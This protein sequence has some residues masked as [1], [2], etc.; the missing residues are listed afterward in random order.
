MSKKNLF[1]IIA[2]ILLLAAPVWARTIGAVA[3]L[4][5]E[6][7]VERAGET[8]PL[9]MES[10]IHL[11]D[12]VITR[13]NA[14]LQILFDDETLLS[15]GEKSE[16]VMDEYVYDPANPQES[17]FSATLGDG[18]FRLITGKLTELN[19]D[20]F[21]LKT[22]RSTIG[23]R[24]TTVGI[25]NYGNVNR[26]MLINI[27]AGH[28]VIVSPSGQEG[29]SRSYNQSGQ[30]VGF[31]ESGDFTE[32][33]L[34]DDEVN[35]LNNQTRPGNG[36]DKNEN[37][38]KNNNGGNDSGETS[39]EE[40]ESD[41]QD[42]SD[43]EQ[44]DAEN[45]SGQTMTQGELAIL[46]AKKIV[47]VDQQPTSMSEITAVNFLLQ[48]GVLPLGGWQPDEPLSLGA[49]AMILGQLLSLNPENPDDE[50]SWLEAGILEG[51]DFTDISSALLT[52][53]LFTNQELATLLGSRLNDP[54][55]REPPGVP[56]EFENA[57]KDNRPFQPDEMTPNR[58]R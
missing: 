46:L 30:D 11:M 53:G 15:L 20:R 57:G 4:E 42:D 21:K 7:V 6:A 17:G 35:N 54:V 45:E 39:G 50:Q 16:V 44:N 48:A 27:P 58:P 38:G 22:S 14:K 19:P 47:P 55:D 34:N 33:P 49:L 36:I 41:D 1:S 18:L 25:R 37:G 8:I 26:I 32:E 40:G 24:G 2:T 51:I 29:Q 31:N 9:A 5:G 23:I 13:E 43:N 12:K 52:S 10:E 28:E 3:G 56:S